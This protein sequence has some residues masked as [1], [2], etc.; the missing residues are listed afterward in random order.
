MN[1]NNGNT[2]DQFN[3]FKANDMG[4]IPYL[5]NSLKNKKKKLQSG[6]AGKKIRDCGNMTGR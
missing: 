3:S 6:L 5:V 4:S 2:S 1:S